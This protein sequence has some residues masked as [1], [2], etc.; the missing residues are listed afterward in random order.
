MTPEDIDYKNLFEGLQQENEK[1]R[2]S[3]MR[4]KL[5][6]SIFAGISWYDIMKLLSDPRYIIGFMVGLICGLLLF[7]SSTRIHIKGG[8][9]Q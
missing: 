5:R 3:I 8:I 6:P 1:L 4:L 2:E 9:A 7:T